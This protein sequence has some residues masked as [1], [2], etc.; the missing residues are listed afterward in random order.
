M[1]N[2][3]QKVMNVQNHNGEISIF[4]VGQAG[5][6]IK[7]ASG[8]LIGLDMYLTDCVERLCNFKRI[9]AKLMAPDELVFDYVIVSHNHPDHFDVDA[10]PIIMG[11][12]YTKM[13]TS[14]CGAEEAKKAGITKNVTVMERGNEY[15]MGDFKIRAVFCD[16]GELAP[17]ALGLIIEVDGYKIYYAGDTA[18][19]PEE[20]KDFAKGNIDVMIAPINGAYGNLNGEQCAL[21]SKLIQPKLTMPCH[22]W[23]FIEHETPGGGPSDFVK[24]MAEICPENKYAFLTQGE[25]IKITK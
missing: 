2:F 15:D 14:V 8:K 21:Y 19:R 23:T 3:A 17:Y 1:A 4:F 18:Y 11:N 16:H 13:A 20:V 5:Y 12:P 25:Y 6:I 9:N 24:A 22:F 10:L 7:T